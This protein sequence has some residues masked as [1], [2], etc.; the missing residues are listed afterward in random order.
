MKKVAGNLK[1]AQAEYRELEA[2]SK[3]GSDLDAATKSVLDK[4]ARNVEIL[5]QPQYTPMLVEHQVAIIFCGTKGLLRSIP[6]TSV[7][8][9]ELDYLNYMTTHHQ[10]VLERLRQ[11]KLDDADTKTMEKVATDF[12]QKYEVKK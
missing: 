8:N 10:D 11:G 5:K 4:G 1:L 6:V 3:F 12:V 7:R 9:F 2:F